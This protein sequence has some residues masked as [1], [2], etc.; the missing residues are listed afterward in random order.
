VQSDSVPGPT[1]SIRKA[2]SPEGG[3]ARSDG[4]AIREAALAARMPCITT[5]AGAAA[6]VHAIAAARHE[7]A[8]SL[9]ERIEAEAVGV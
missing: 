2:S 7:E 8:L 4:Y 5:L 9:Q 1:G 3:N 6:A